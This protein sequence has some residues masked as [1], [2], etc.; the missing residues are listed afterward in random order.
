MTM[1]LKMYFIL[2]SIITS[3]ILLSLALSMVS[4]VYEASRTL[5]FVPGNHTVDSDYATDGSFTDVK[6]EERLYGYLGGSRSNFVNEVFHEIAIRHSLSSSGFDPKSVR[7]ALQNLELSFAMRGC[8]VMCIRIRSSN[9][10]VVEQIATCCVSAASRLAKDTNKRR[11]AVSAA[12][13]KELVNKQRS[14]VDK[15]ENEMG[16]GKVNDGL[17]KAL[18]EN[19]ELLNSLQKQL[20]W[21]ENS[22]SNGIVVS[23][24]V[25]DR[26]CS[27]YV[28]KLFSW[29]LWGK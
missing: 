22:N 29:G 6:S 9:S 26:T 7:H 20:D 24:V 17:V 27:H 4:D 15:I 8:P 21:M 10:N 18:A 28:G 13:F 11:N 5:A 14:V 2:T 23:E 16:N 12:Q 3:V 19:H 25:S 1:K